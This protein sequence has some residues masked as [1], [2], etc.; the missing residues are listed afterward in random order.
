MFEQLKDRLQLTEEQ[1]RDYSTRF[2]RMEVP[3][4]TILLH[5]GDVPS[6]AFY[7]EKGCLRIWANNDGKDLTMQFF[8]ENSIVA[9][10]ESFKKGLPS[11]LSIEAVEPTVLWYISR[12]DMAQIISDLCEQPATRQLFI[13][14]IFGRTFNYMKLFLSFVRDTPKQRYLQLV[15][16]R[17]EIVQRVPQHYIASYLGI[18]TVHLSRIK[19]QLAKEKRKVI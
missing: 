12:D 15:S 19:S 5:E 16:E 13:D 8:F 6:R 4:R 9:S 14:F 7:V 1:W 10:L 3:A 2:K 18:S 17:P 11:P